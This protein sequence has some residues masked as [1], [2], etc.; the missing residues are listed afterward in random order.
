MALTLTL[1]KFC[2]AHPMMHQIAPHP[3]MDTWSCFIPFRRIGTGTLVVARILFL[4]ETLAS[5]SIHGNGD[6]GSVE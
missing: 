6:M 5:L 1:K 2:V 4:R 3:L